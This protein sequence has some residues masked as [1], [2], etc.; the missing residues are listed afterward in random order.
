[1]GSIWGKWFY[2]ICFIFLIVISLVIWVLQVIVDICFQQVDGFFVE[3]EVWGVF[4]GDFNNDCCFDLFVNYYWD[5]V[6]FYKNNCDGIFMDVIKKVDV[7]FVW[8]EG[9]WFVD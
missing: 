2:C 6:V 1:M 9:N 7:D 4:W 8:L 3:V 5:E